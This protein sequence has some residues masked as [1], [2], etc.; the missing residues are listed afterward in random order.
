MHTIA[1]QILVA[2]RPRCYAVQCGLAGYARFV[3]E[4]APAG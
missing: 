4:D 1:R 2:Q 3:S